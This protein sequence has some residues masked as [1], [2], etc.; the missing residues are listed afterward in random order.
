MKILTNIVEV[1][2]Y[3]FLFAGNL[4]MIIIQ[5]NLRPNDIITYPDNTFRLIKKLNETCNEPRLMFRILYQN[6]TSNLIIIHDH[7]IL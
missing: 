3:Q 7:N 2:N 5:I 6:G 1:R 4:F